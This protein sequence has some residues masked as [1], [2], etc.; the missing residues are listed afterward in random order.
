MIECGNLDLNFPIKYGTLLLGKTKR[1][2][3]TSAHYLMHQI[4][5]GGYNDHNSIVYILDNGQARFSSAKI[6]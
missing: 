1:G 4:L 3:T 2:K 6:G 5:K